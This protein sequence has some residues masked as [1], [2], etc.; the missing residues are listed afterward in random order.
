MSTI[1]LK[2]ASFLYRNPAAREAWL[3]I[4][5]DMERY[6]DPLLTPESLARTK[7]SGSAA[8]RDR[9]KENLNELDG[10]YSQ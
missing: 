1:E 3:Q 9:I 6:V 10:L 4:D 2:F 7:A 8:F 5:E